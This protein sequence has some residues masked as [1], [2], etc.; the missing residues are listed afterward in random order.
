[1][2]REAI[3]G[4]VKVPEKGDAVSGDVAVPRE[5]STVNPGLGVS[6]R[7]FD[8][9]ISSGSFK[10]SEIIVKL[11]DTITMN[12]TATD[13]D[14]DF[15]MPDFGLSVPLLKGVKKTVQMD[16]TAAG[17]FIFYCKVCGGP[18]KGPRGSLTISP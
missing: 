13:G 7:V 11:K 8:I 18:E 2:T 15:T 6:K 12:F 3:S 17:K 10:P 5:V 16:A 4:P 14:Y 1:V 9:A